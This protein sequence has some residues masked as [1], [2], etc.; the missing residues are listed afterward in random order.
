[1]LEKQVRHMTD[2]V[3]KRK[4]SAVSKYDHPDHGKS[5]RRIS[6]IRGQID[7]IDRMI[8]ERRYCP[9]I[10]VQIRAATAALK[11][12]EAEILKTHLRGCVKSAFRTKDPFEVET[13]IEE[14]MKMLS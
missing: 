12:L 3:G 8:D 13:K 5:K 2:N 1:M 14:I 9:E 7:G 6:R 11:A 10:I 4:N